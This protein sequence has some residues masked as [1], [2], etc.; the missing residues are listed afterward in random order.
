M[1]INN[2][3][4]EKVKADP[5]IIHQNDEI[6]THKWKWWEYF[7][8][9]QEIVLEIGTGMGNFFWKQ[10]WENPDKNY[11]GM[12]IRYKRL[13]QTAEKARKADN[14]QFVMLKDFAQNIDQIFVEWEISESYIFFPDPWANKD[15]QRKNRLLQANFLEHLY[16]VTRQGGK[17]Y[18]KTDHREYFD[19]TREI[20]EEQGLWKVVA[21]THDYENSEI[22]D[23]K[24]ITEFEWLYRGEKIDINYIELEK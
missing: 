10:V 5:D 22:F 9:N 3:Y 1:V 2:P 17:L 15:R 8:N 24:N 6:Y 21:W 16:K 11:I 12:E 23:M 14:R 4:I 7:W 19:S 20:I 13:F 18:F